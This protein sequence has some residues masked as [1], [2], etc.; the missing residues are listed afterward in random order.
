MG[1]QG[2]RKPALQELIAPE[3]ESPKKGGLTLVRLVG[4]IGTLEDIM[5][6]K[7]EK[8]HPWVGPEPIW[9]PP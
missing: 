2:D 4:K 9:G 5:P 7:R 8:A 3:L 6:R 1:G